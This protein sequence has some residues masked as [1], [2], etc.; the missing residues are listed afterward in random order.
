MAF[1]VPSNSNDSM[2]HLCFIVQKKN[3]IF[4]IFQGTLNKTDHQNYLFLQMR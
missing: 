2:T 1:M 4:Q 3:V